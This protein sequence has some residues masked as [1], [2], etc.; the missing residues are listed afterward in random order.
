[1]KTAIKPKQKGDSQLAQLQNLE[2]IVRAEEGTASLA[3]FFEAER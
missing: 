1:M 2:L 3:D